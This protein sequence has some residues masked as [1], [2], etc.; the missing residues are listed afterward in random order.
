[1]PLFFTLLVF[2]FIHTIHSHIH[3][4]MNIR[5]GPS[6]F[7]HRWSVQWQTPPWGA[8]FES[9]YVLPT[10]LCRLVLQ[11]KVMLQK[12]VVHCVHPL[13]SK[14]LIFLS[15]H[16]PRFSLIILLWLTLLSKKKL[17][18]GWTALIGVLLS[19]AG[20]DLY[21]DG[22]CKWLAV[23]PGLARAAQLRITVDSAVAIAKILCPL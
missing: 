5:R 8:E 16:Y 11:W 10:E 1:M 20:H 2:S 7:P 6:P 21:C 9:C 4:S 14:S 17:K 13:P 3:T 12:C 22:S 19:M 18:V 23:L 15:R